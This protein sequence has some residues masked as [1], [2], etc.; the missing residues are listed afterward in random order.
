ML[1]YQLSALAKRP[2][3]AARV[4]LDP[5]D[6]SRADELAYLQIIRQMLRSLA[7]EVNQRLLPVVESDMKSRRLPGQVVDADPTDP[8]QSLLALARMLANVASSTVSTILGLSA[9]KHTKG[10]MQ[11]AKKALGVDLSA[12]VAEGDL[13]ELLRLASL[14]NAGL[15]TNIAESTVTRISTTVTNALLRGDPVSVLRKQIA[16]DFGFSDRRAKIVARDQM[17]KL[18]SDLNRFRHTQAGIEK[19]TW[20]T[21][22]DERV[23]PLHRRLNG[24][25]YEYGKPTGAEQGL[26]PGQ[27]I[28]CRCIAAPVVEWDTSEDAPVEPRAP[29]A[30]V[31]APP[32]A[33]VPVKGYVPPPSDVRVLPQ[34]REG[35]LEYG[36]KYGPARANISKDE[37]SALRRYAGNDYAPINEGLR[38]GAVS[39]K[40]QQ[41]VRDLDTY[42][43]KW[44]LP[45]ELTTFRGVKDFEKLAKGL[46]DI[47]QL[48][49]A[50]IQ[51]QAFVSTSAHLTVAQHFAGSKFNPRRA[52]FE[53]A[54]PKGTKALPAGPGAARAGG[55]VRY[56]DE[57]EFILKR[58]A[59]FRVIEVHKSGSKAIA[60][61]NGAFIPRVVL[62]LIP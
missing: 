34:T 15:I 17:A 19:Y 51:D 7:R 36:R 40:Y 6:G 12:V 14:R 2:R 3:N 22:A 56:Q 59:R 30:P 43:D 50:E 29:I 9:Q 35:Y 23:R 48:L 62:E 5:V 53:I 46:T 8:I 58:G 41:A 13:S 52:V 39:E 10:F 57:A 49:G 42:I 33:P 11:T 45:T 55:S 24:L 47:E 16:A 61:D 31:N 27:P 60:A 54:L 38:K 1:R 44:E 28:L 21:S 37:L 25:V 20:S 4:T 18:N 26:P 32:S